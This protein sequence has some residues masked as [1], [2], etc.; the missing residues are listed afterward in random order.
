VAGADKILIVGGGIAGLS[1]AAALSRHGFTPELVERSPAWPAAGAGIALH[2][3]AGR[4]LRALGL[5]EAIARGAATLPRWSFLDQQGGLLCET[6]LADL[7]GEAGPCMG[8]TCIRLQEIL[9]AAAGNARHRLGVAVTALAREA[10]RV[11]VGFSDG[12]SGRYDL[13]V[14]ADGPVP[15]YLAALE[16]DEQLHFGP[17]NG[18]SPAAG[19]TAGSSSSATPPM[20]RRRTWAKAAPWPWRTPWCRPS[21]SPPQARWRTRSERTRPG[22]DRGPTGSS[23]RA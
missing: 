9:A 22:A 8:I 14:G 13:V 16:L 21:C 19:A 2:A 18:W 15:A 11:S 4:M 7:W 5:G 10:G 17:S 1:L 6:D 12:S 3:N 23:S 20:R